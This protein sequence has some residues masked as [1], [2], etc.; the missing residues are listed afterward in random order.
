MGALLDSLHYTEEVAGG[1]LWVRVT[2]VP[3]NGLPDLL[4]DVLHSSV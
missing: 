4:L 1:W 2:W 3:N